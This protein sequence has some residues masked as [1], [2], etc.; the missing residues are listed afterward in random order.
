MSAETIESLVAQIKELKEQMVL[1]KEELLREIRSLKEK[2]DVK[3]A[4][5]K[6]AQEAGK[7]T[8]SYQNAPERKSQRRRSHR[9]ESSIIVFAEYRN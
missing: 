5:A 4:G 1:Q 9:D 6:H 8:A 2:R 3:P 7:Q